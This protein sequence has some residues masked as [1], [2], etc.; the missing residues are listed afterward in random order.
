MT[1]KNPSDATS[2]PADVI[3]LDSYRDP[4]DVRS[5][6]LLDIAAAL[7]A[8]A[9]SIRSQIASRRLGINE[10]RLPN[11][12]ERDAIEASSARLR[13][14]DACLKTLRSSFSPIAAALAEL[15][16]VASDIDDALRG[17]E[18]PSIKQLVDAGR[19]ATAIMNHDDIEGN[20]LYDGASEAWQYAGLL[21]GELIVAEDGDVVCADRVAS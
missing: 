4:V 12:E 11:A 21:S 14:R 6:E 9:A 2:K 13:D 15:A 19:I 8:S 7:R 5:R 16:S 10:P 20:S 18:G 3:D 1:H 17:A